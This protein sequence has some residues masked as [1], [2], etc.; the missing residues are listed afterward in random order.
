MR[1]NLM[2]KNHPPR[3]CLRSTP[4]TSLCYRRSTRRSEVKRRSTCLLSSQVSKLPLQ[5]VILDDDTWRSLLTSPAPRSQPGGQRS[6]GGQLTYSRSCYQLQSSFNYIPSYT[7]TDIILVM[8]R[9]D[10]YDTKIFSL[11]LFQTKKKRKTEE[12]PKRQMMVMTVQVVNVLNLVSLQWI[13]LVYLKLPDLLVRYNC[14]STSF[15]S[16]ISLLLILSVSFSPFPSFVSDY[17]SFS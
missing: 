17:F 2:S 3:D 16:C 7:Y 10:F 11:I 4:L 12:M 9:Y 15:S 14:V 13:Y 1:S 8:D 5:I 6:G